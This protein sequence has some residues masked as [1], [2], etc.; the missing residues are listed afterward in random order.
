MVS[1]ETQFLTTKELAD[2]LR[3]KERKVYDLVASGEVPCTRATGKLLFP[4]QGIQEWIASKA[5]G[6]GHTSTPGYT[7]QHQAR[8]SVF[9]GSHD[10]LLEWALRESDCGLAM[11]FDSSQ[12]GL[13]RFSEYQGVA[14]GLHLFDDIS[15]Q[16]NLHAVEKRFAN[17]DVVLVEF[18]RRQRG[19]I[20][21]PGQA[22]VV[23]SFAD[24]SGK[25]LVSR[26]Q[27]AGSQKLLLQLIAREGLGLKDYVCSDVARTEADAALTVGAGKADAALGLQSLAQQY[28][29]DFMPLVEERFDLLVDRKA[30]FEPPMQRFVTFCQSALFRQKALEY[31]G[32]DVSDFGRV[33]FNSEA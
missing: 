10:P 22:E 24:L 12:D 21:Q 33:W 19:L 3:I 14:S 13:D 17:T 25:R 8:N 15:D 32:Y 16:W 9:L 26:Q 27:G 7:T 30:W 4:R 5:E 20:L 23:S 6:L 31:Q 1:L 18:A 2:L 28:S 11:L 29:L